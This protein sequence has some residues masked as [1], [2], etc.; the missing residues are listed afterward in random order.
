MISM[1]AV[2][3]VKFIRTGASE[4]THPVEYMVSCAQEDSSSLHRCKLPSVSTRW[5]CPGLGI[6]RIHPVLRYGES[7]WEW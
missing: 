4:F 3:F 6:L 7:P 2:L 1:N 5:P